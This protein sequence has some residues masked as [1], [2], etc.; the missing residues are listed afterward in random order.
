MNLDGVTPAKADLAIIVPYEWQK[1][2]GDFSK[3]GLAGSEA[4][5]YTSVYDGGAV[6]GAE[7]A[8]HEQENAWLTG[9]WLS[10]MT[11]IFGIFLMRQFLISIPNDLLDAA[12]IDGCDELGVFARVIFP[13][14]LPGLATLIVFIFMVADPKSGSLTR[15]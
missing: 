10:S 7:P 6:E 4:T 9:S 11:S 8:K 12:R 1:P 13:L 14:T 5:P 3:M 2:A 15:A